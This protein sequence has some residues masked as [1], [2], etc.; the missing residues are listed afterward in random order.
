VRSY[1]CRAD[2]CTKR[3]TD[4]YAYCR[5]DGGTYSCTYECAD[6]QA[7][8]CTYRCTYCGAD[9]WTDGYAHFHTHGCAY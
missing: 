5:A 8:S 7:Y 9:P 3:G 1:H 2:R 4:D 6:R